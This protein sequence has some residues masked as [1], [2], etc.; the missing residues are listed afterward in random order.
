MP[1]LGSP[2]RSLP[3]GFG[4]PGA[5]VHRRQSPRAS[6]RSKTPSRLIVW[7]SVIAVAF[8]ASVARAQESI[9]A[10]GKY[11]LVAEALGPFI[12]QERK[13]K[14]IPAIMIALVDD[15]EIVWAQGFGTADRRKNRPATAET[16]VR[17]GSVSKLFADLA[18]MQLVERGEVDLDRPVS[19]YL[20]EFRPENPFDEAITLRQLMSH[21]SGLVREPPVGH[22]FDPT[23]PSIADTVASL[24][25][26]KL[27]YP[28]T[29]R[30][31]YSNAAVTVVGRLVEAKA[32]EPFETAVQKAVLGPMGLKR[33]SFTLTAEL[34]ADLAK[35]VMWTYD[36]R[37][38]EAPTFALGTSPAGNLYSTVNDL[39][40]FLTVLFAGGEGPGGR[41]LKPETLETMY[42]P[43]FADKRGRGGFGLGFA[44][45]D[46]DGALRVGHGGAV[47]GFA[48]E[49]AALPKEK[50]GVVVVSTKDC[51]NDVSET[52]ASEALRMMRAARDGKSL[53]IP[54]PT[55]PLPAETAQAADGRYTRDGRGVDLIRRGKELFFLPTEGGAMARVR[56]QGDEL[57][58]D[59]TLASGPS[60]TLD[61]DS[62]VI[63]RNRLDREPPSEGPPPP[64]PERWQGLIGEYGWDHDILYILEK[65]GRLHALIEWFYLYPLEEVSEN[66]FKFP[67]SGLYD[68]ERL[69]FTRDESGRATKVEAASVV[70]E[71]RA[72][73][74]E[75][76]KTFQ[77][78]PVRP[79]EEL[80]KEALAASP[81]EEKGGFRE[82]DLV[83]LSGIDP[84]IKLD[85][86]YAGTNNFLGTPFYS[87]AR[88]FLQRPAAEA[89]EKAHLKLKERGY[90][91]LIH[92]AYRPWYV[93]KMFWDATT[94]PDRGF[95]ADPS[96]GS[97][98][99]RGCAVDLSMY[100]LK[101][102]EPVAMVGGYDEFSPR[103]NPDYPGGTSRQRWLRDLLR[104]AMEDEGFTVN[105]VEWW[106]FDFKDWAKYPI[107]N[108]PF[109]RLD[110]P[111]AAEP[112]AEAET[113]P[114]DVTAPPAYAEFLVIPLR[115]HILT[116]DQLPDADCKLSE[117]DIRR[118]VGK[119]NGVWNKAGI[120]FGLESVACEPA[121]GVEQFRRAREEHD[122]RRGTPLGLYRLLIPDGD[123]RRFDGLHVYYLHAFPVNGVYMGGDYAI[124]QET[125]RLRPV[126]GGIDEPLPRVTAHEL[127][128][129]LGLSHRQNR[130]NLLASG[131]T[132]TLLNAVEVAEARARAP[133]WKGTRTVAD[134]RRAAEEAASRGEREHARRLW[135]WLSE[136]PG[137][138]AEEAR[139]RLDDLG[140]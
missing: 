61:G 132:G 119:V 130:T 75:D 66:E 80:R 2:D 102:G 65:D 77:I 116:S 4:P 20:P 120:H 47:Y 95:V 74:G 56:S 110:A 28:P 91:L 37:T 18:A 136:I 118:I 122:E 123:R 101:T 25:R 23:S 104:R 103:S 83:E 94:G 121:A 54:E 39:G 105:E 26:T 24:N 12:E 34:E 126:E 35:A 134:L 48:T 6:A 9:P 88:A 42:E 31:K 41:V 85:I 124:V 81:P 76:G 59:D 68:G 69:I 45:G 43:Q 79:V 113:A 135:T 117:I 44:L 22:Y 127:G 53:T 72:I 129:A 107:L 29:T 21:R 52:I 51:A 15:Q 27:V 96:K 71:R 137:E 84:S 86:R 89:L 114:P 92:D 67:T 70:F 133:R 82:P 8:G 78:R 125:A 46:L 58:V 10:E 138:G 115:I 57:V 139:R 64:A 106:H 49:V 87:Q 108:V 13:D 97:K 63:G 7:A 131:T 5:C 33:S 112:R 36:G 50:L 62:L 1:H 60:M 19:E 93:T 99:N 38:F 140:D 40:R 100:D 32:G 111:D 73:A 55:G 109:E 11:R 90:G 30:T 98:H 14:A 16:V 3:R 17:V 128:H